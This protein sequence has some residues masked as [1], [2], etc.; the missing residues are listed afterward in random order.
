MF[1]IL[2]WLVVSMSVTELASPY[3]VL[4]VFSLPLFPAHGFGLQDL[5]H[6]DCIQDTVCPWASIRF[7]PCEVPRK[8][9]K[10]GKRER[11]GTY[12]MNSAGL[13]TAGQLLPLVSPQLLSDGLSLEFFLWVLVNQPLLSLRFRSRVVKTG[14]VDSIIFP[15][16]LHY[17]L[18]P[19]LKPFQH[20]C[21]H[22]LYQTVRNG[23]HLNVPSDFC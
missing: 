8:R 11:L 16:A 22:S 5:T 10:A 3:Y 14:G 15:E 9:S 18:F 17:P 19:F 21:K 4:D 12:S 7:G 23:F 2:S 1:L 20:L 6:M 13:D